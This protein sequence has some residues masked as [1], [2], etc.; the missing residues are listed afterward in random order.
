[1]H[2]RAVSASPRTVGAG[3]RVVD[4]LITIRE[5]AAA[6]TPARARRMLPLLPALALVGLLAVCLALLAWR[7]AHAYDEFLAEQG[8]LSLHQYTTVLSDAQFHKVLGR[9]ILVSAITPLVAVALAVP[10]ALTLARSRSRALRL[11]LLVGMF[12]PIL[13][14]DITRTYGWL[15]TLG[16]NGPIDWLS[17]SI[18]LGD[19]QVI[20]TLW[21]IGIG[22]VQ[23]LVPV[24]I[25]ILLPAA[26]RTD[27]ELEMAAATM[28]AAPRV[29]FLR[30]TLPQLRAA[31]VAAI[32]TD[33]ALAM[34]AFADPAILGRGLRNFV[35][36]FLQDRYLGVGNPPQGAAIGILMLLIVSVGSALVLTLGRVRIRRPR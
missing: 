10:V 16:P 24:A 26:L 2:S 35:G 17:N 4:A 18:G 11:V 36:N 13:T 5:R 21:A 31:I 14:G 6:W 29:V 30:V 22:V 12:V 7:S 28:G 15:V 33:F 1:M 9:T 27:P 23:I 32:A 8:A 3:W 19:V 34:A 25:V 20:G